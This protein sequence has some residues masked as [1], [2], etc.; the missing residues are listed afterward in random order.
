MA[1]EGCICRLWSRLGNDAIGEE[2]PEMLFSVY[3]SPH[4]EYLTSAASLL[5]VTFPLFLSA[6]N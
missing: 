1:V 5:H 4:L 6:E 3:V 2:V